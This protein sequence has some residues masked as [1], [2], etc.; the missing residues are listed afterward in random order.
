MTWTTLLRRAGL[1]LALALAVA[2]HIA[3][4]KPAVAA[5]L[6]PQD[7]TDVQRI[8]RYLNEIRTLASPFL[9]V[10]P[11]GSQS[12]GIL[13]LSRPGR[14]RIDYEPPTNLL[15]VGAG[16][17]MVV[18][19]RDLKQANYIGIDQTPIGVL[20]REQIRLAGDVTV[21][22]FERGANVIRLTLARSDDAEAG[23]VTLAFDDRPLQLR[24]WVV[25]DPQGTETRVSLLD[26]RL[27]VQF[28]AKLFDFVP[29]D[30]STVRGRQ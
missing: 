5:K 24:Q 8:E 19:D 12:R 11:D 9:Q 25:I 26:P 1:A 23:R 28:D 22:R 15:V 21:T 27:G 6:T 20:V 16:G 4:A 14:I 17:S 10:A 30:R 3:A 7:S 13:S 18:Y 2:P 29:P